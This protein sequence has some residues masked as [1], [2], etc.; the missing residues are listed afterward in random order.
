MQE[1]IVLHYAAHGGH[2]KCI[3][4]VFAHTSI[5]VNSAN[6]YGHTALSIALF[7][8]RFQAAKLVKIGWMRVG[9]GGLRRSRRGLVNRLERR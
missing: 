8:N 2:L 1:K 7:N 9:R 3:D 4:F 5:A 6:S